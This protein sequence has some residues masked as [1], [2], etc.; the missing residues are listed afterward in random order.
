MILAGEVE[1]EGLPSAKPGTR[2]DGDASLVVRPRRPPRVGRAGEKLETALDRFGIDPAGRIALDIGASIGGFTECLLRRGAAHVVALDVGRGQ[3]DWSLRNDA[4][5]TP[6]EGV[7]ARHL[8]PADLPSPGRDPDLV[9]CDVSFISLKLVLPAIA[10]VLERGD[11]IVLV[12]PQFEAGRGKVGRGGILRDVSERERTLREVAAA[13][14]G[15]GFH[16]ARACVSGLPG[17]GGNIEY[18]LHLRRGAG[19]TDAPG[20]GPD[21]ERS[22]LE[23][24]GGTG[25]APDEGGGS[26]GDR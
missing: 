24:I 26:N 6:L 18:F 21:L 4:R 20:A 3:L 25:A 19:G 17:A 15:E 9:V 16:V 7:N 2:V 23:A 22:I 14:A 8:R 13:A 1:V 5:V 11:A 10:G 12:K